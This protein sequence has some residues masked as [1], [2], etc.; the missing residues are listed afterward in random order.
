MS[1]APESLLLF[2]TQPDCPLCD[3]AWPVAER[4][5]ERFDLELRRVDISREP[6][7]QELHGERIPVLQL[8]GQTLGWG[9]LSERGIESRMRS[10]GIR[11]A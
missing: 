10:L 9:R 8:R 1:T 5:A 4:I 2:Y 11:D 7:L 3:K 6:K